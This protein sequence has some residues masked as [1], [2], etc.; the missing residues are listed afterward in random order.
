M[1]VA[2][3]GMSHHS[4]PIE[5]RERLSLSGDEISRLLPELQQC[6]GIRECC[7]LSTC[8]R[9]EFY[10][11]TDHWEQSKEALLKFIE[12]K[13][14]LSAGSVHEHVY[15]HTLLEAVRR[16][17][18]VTA[19]LDS[20][21]L[22]ESQIAGQVKNA[23]EMARQ[24]GATG[25][26]LNTLFQ[27]ALAASKRVRTKTGIDR[28]PVSIPYI[29]TI[30]MKRAL[31]SLAGRSVLLLGA[32][33][34]G[35][36][37]MKGLRENGVADI[38]VANRSADRAR[39]LAAACGGRAVALAE[40]PDCLVAAD[41][42]IS[43]AAAPSYLITAETAA[44]AMALRRGRPL[45]LVDM[46]APREIDPLA[47][48]IPGVTLFD[49]DDFQCVEDESWSR[50]R[51][52]A[53]Q[54]EEIITE[55]CESF[56]ARLAVNSV[57]PTI[58]A[59]TESFQAVQTEEVELALRRLGEYD[60]RQAEAMNLLAASLT[61]KLLHRPIR[62]LRA[63][64]LKPEG[65]MYAKMVKSLFGLDREEENDEAALPGW[66]QGK[67]AGSAADGMVAEPAEGDLPAYSV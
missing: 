12:T 56:M 54:G 41:I 8:N 21:A 66:E 38:I 19:G 25:P 58:R 44:R 13:T 16:L 7:V 57:A 52:A 45:L 10:L 60:D 9:T 30:L 22:G 28:C 62:A 40:A 11:T 23:Y 37:V 34:M 24:A 36:A 43:A 4:A 32:G 63:F 17:F 39:E 49:L 5:L 2:V 59:L 14:G 27:H 50:R 29:A 33:K 26:V 46:S 53:D 3:I 6:A 48:E 61:A 67:P 31:G 35:T 18:R 55:E 20:M 65:H 64:A 47:K 1:F 42:V 51:L 15:A